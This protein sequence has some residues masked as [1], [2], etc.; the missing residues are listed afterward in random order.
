MT[1]PQRPRAGL[2]FGSAITA[3]RMKTRTLKS[4]ALGTRKPKPI[5]SRKPAREKP[6]AKA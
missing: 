1:K 4:Q 3:D 6:P 5:T 2:G